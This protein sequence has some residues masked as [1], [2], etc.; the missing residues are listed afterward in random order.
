MSAA[1]D[2]QS[3]DRGDRHGRVCEIEALADKLIALVEEFEATISEGR[4]PPAFERRLAELRQSA[5]RLIDP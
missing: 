5:E 3:G 4:V 2:K 1:R